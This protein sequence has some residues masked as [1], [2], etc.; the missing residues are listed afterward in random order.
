MT[1]TPHSLRLLGKLLG[2]FLLV[3]FAPAQYLFVFL[4]ASKTI[5]R[6]GA[7]E[8][9]ITWMPAT[10]PW[11]F[12]TVDSP[13]AILWTICAISMLPKVQNWA[14]RT[15]IWLLLLAAA[16]GLPAL[17]L[18]LLLNLGMP[19]EQLLVQLPFASLLLVY[20]W[21]PILMKVKSR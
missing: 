3:I 7:V 6:Q 5:T 19:L 17:G 13:M 9:V 11:W 12:F 18:A 20:T 21:T 4:L 14:I 2:I 1:Q 8:Q 16:V 10:M 15:R